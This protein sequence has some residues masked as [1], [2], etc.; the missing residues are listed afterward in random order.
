MGDGWR[1]RRRR[2]IRRMQGTNSHEREQV[3]LKLTGSTEQLNVSNRSQSG[4]RK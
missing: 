1:R 3:E 2:R 4:A